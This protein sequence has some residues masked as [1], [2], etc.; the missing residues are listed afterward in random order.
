ML[1]SLINTISVGPFVCPVTDLA[2]VFL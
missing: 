1:T 2:S